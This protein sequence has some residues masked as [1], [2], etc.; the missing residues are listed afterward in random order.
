MGKIYSPK[1]INK[2]SQNFYYEEILTPLLVNLDESKGNMI[3]LT[4]GSF[5]PIHRMHLEILNIAYKHLSSFN[6]YN[7]ICGFISPSADCYVRT[8]PPPLIPFEKRCEMIQTAI[9][10]FNQENKDKKNE[11]I[12][13]YIHKW[14]GSHNYFIDFPDVINVI[15]QQLNKIKIKIKKKITLLYVCGMDHYIKCINALKKN[16]VII[17]RKP[18]KKE[19]IPQNNPEKMIFFFRDENSE[20]YSSTSIK[21]YYKKQ[22]L[23]NI[24]K[25][26]FENVAKIIVEFY[27]EYYK[28]N[29]INSNFI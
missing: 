10:D 25:S 14:E 8:K 29:E 5:N 13:I 22:D 26:T 6:E 27:D 1:E 4:T 9:D 23:E 19:Y 24:K 28:K 20:E 15:Q 7:I 12:K 2:N 18:F 16:V 21:E 3:L 17:D 11:I